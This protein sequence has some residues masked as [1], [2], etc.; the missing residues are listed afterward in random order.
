MYSLACEVAEN[1]HVNSLN[2][3]AVV[4]IITSQLLTVRHQRIFHKQTIIDQ[5]LHSSLIFS[6]S[7]KLV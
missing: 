3:K 1:K 2:S 7:S 5:K 4:S 6:L